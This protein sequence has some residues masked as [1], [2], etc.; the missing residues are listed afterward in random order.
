MTEEKHKN[1]HLQSKSSSASERIAK[2]MARA[3]LCSRRDAERWIA[4]GRVSVNGEILKTPACVV[5]EQDEIVVNGKPIKSKE[6]TKLYLYHKPVGLVTTHKDE[7]GRSTIFQNLPSNLPRVISVGRLDL[8]TEGLLLLTND[9]ELSRYLE[10]PTTGWKRKYRV[11]VHGIIDS[12]KLDGLKKGIVVDGVSYRSIIAEIDEE[13]KEKSGA[14][15]WL[16][17]T[18]KEGKNREIRK[19]MEALGLRVNRLIRVSYGPFQLGTMTPGSVQEVKTQVMKEQI[20]GFFVG[21]K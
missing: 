10:L 1:N 11:R 19:V 9:G 21:K 4:E 5:T 17:I 12:K 7:M 20:K 6:Q 3:G 15:T 2:V 18:L 8:N 13:A 16:N 14:N